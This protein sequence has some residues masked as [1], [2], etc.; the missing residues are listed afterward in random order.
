MDTPTSPPLPDAASAVSVAS[1]AS[2][3]MPDVPSSGPV[4]APVTAKTTAV[5]GSRH[6]HLRPS[7]L[8]TAIA[9][10]GTSFGG[11]SS[12]MREAPLAITCPV[13]EIQPR[14]SLALPSGSLAKYDPADVLEPVLSVQALQR[15]YGDEMGAAFHE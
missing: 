7:E 6:E 14:G 3:A 11:C 15:T 10:M 9:A 12:K 5:A 4:A 8:A 13:P 2:A 1:A